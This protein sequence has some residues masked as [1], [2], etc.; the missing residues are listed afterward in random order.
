MDDELPKEITQSLQDLDATITSLEKILE[1]FFKE[2]LADIMQRLSPL[3]AAK[4]NICMAYAV[5]TLYYL[6]LKTQGVSP[7]E[8]PVKKELER[9]RLYIQKIKSLTEGKG[10]GPSL[11]IDQ[12]ATSRMLQHSLVTKKQPDKTSNDARSITT[13]ITQSASA[14]SSSSKSKKRKVSEHRTGQAISNGTEKNE[15]TTTSTQSSKDSVI[16]TNASP[17]TQHKKKKRKNLINATF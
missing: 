3:E 9:V 15:E 14:T 4:L 12:A 17:T 10:P 13:A 1:P 5:N 11:R 6:F 2:N 16:V 8:H 7:A